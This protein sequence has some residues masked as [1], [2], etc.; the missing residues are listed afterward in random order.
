[1]KLWERLLLYF[2]STVSLV[3]LIGGIVIFGSIHSTDMSVTHTLAPVAAPDASSPAEM[4]APAVTGAE[5]SRD[6]GHEPKLEYWWAE[7]KAGDASAELSAPAAMGPPGS[8]R[9]QDE[10]IRP[11]VFET[12]PASS[13]FSERLGAP[14]RAKNPPGPPV[15]SSAGTNTPDTQGPPA[16]T[17]GVHQ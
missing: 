2:S 14:D 9:R 6:Q 16:G 17:P 7:H 8:R 5:A 4:P 11:P 13:G 1:M 15:G 12:A 10:L 3:V